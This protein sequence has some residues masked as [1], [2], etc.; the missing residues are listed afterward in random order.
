VSRKGRA[1]I[2]DEMLA[3][4]RRLSVAAVALCLTQRHI[5]VLNLVS[6]QDVSLGQA[7]RSLLNN[8]S[9]FQ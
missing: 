8:S 1:K 2:D 5:S 6:Y 7:K 4:W 3:A 9:V